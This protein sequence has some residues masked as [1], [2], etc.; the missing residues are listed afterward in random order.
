MPLDIKTR[1]VA[2]HRQ[3]YDRGGNIMGVRGWPS[4]GAFR[5]DAA[6]VMRSA[7]AAGPRLEL[8]A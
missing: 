6:S 3:K 5:G 7:G 2:G 1:A 4:E 8:S